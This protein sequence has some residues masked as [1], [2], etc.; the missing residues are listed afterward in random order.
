M[1]VYHNPY[2][3]QRAQAILAP[4]LLRRTKNSTLE[5]EPILKLPPKEIQLVKLD[6]SVDEREVSTS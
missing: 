3:G 2:P 5:G 1:L 4:L 6:F